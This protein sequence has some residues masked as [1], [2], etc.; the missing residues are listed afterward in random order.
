M[1]QPQP[2]PGDRIGSEQRYTL[3]ERI[4]AGGM[5]EVWLARDERLDRDVALKLLTTP[6][7][8]EDLSGELV[9]EARL[10][11]RL[12]HPSIVAVYD[13]GR[14][15]GQ[16][17]IVM[18]YVEGASLREVLAGGALPEAEAVRIGVAVAGALHYAHEAGITHNDIKPENILLPSRG[19]SAIKVT[20]F[21]VAGQV[22]ATLPPEQAQALLGTIAYLAPEVLQGEAP[23]PASDVYALGLVLFELLAGRLPFA[24][25]SPAAVAGQRLAQPAPLLRLFV[26]MASAA[27]EAT[28]ARALS[29]APAGRFRSA[30]ELGAALR[31]GA[32]RVRPSQ[33]VPTAPLPPPQQVPPRAAPVRR[34]T[35]PV[36]RTAAQRT[37]RGSSQTTVI[38]A[39]TAVV[40]AF[41][42]AS[43]V[44][45]AILLTNGGGDDEPTPTPSPQPSTT[46]TTPG[47]TATATNT[48]RPRPTDEPTLTPTPT[49]TPTRAATVTAT[50]T[51]QPPTST[52]TSAPPTATPTRTATPTST[53]T[54]QP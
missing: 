52:P 10:V 22:T 42:A 48:V 54:Q 33:G 9:R 4:G 14:H 49:V 31:A 38:L 17:Y 51:S 20:D 11:A 50:A 37:G 1:A 24:G 2:Q 19:P 15:L 3:L 27:L 43:V 29:P 46:R 16:P 32:A 13:A 40:L 44:T 6:A 26:P 30:A 39:I 53:A 25:A 41:L 28:L 47:A 34:P 21:G 45:A 7:A 12:Q 23:G 5:A 8:L 35:A 18:E 36:R